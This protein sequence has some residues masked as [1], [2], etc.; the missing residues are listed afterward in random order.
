[1]ITGKKPKLKGPPSEPPAQVVEHKFTWTDKCDVCGA[2][3]AE[4]EDGIK[5]KY[6]K[7]YTRHQVLAGKVFRK[8]T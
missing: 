6:C 4:I 7:T 2:T 1:M 3:L 8:V 5:P